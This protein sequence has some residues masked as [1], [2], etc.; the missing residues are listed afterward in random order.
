[1][2]VHLHKRKSYRHRVANNQKEPKV[3]KFLTNRHNEHHYAEQ[4]PHCIKQINIQ[5]RWILNVWFGII[6]DHIIGPEFIQERV[7]A[8]YY[9]NFLLNRLNELLEN[10]PLAHRARMIF[11]QDG[12]P[13]HT[14]HV[15]RHIL[16]QKFPN[17]WIGLHGPQVWPPRS[18]NL[19][20]LDFFAW[21]FLKNKIYENNPEN[22]EDLKTKIRNACN[23]ISSRMLRRV[24][25]NFIRRVALCL[26][27]NSGHFEHLL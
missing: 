7:N 3:Y 4:N 1:M 15:V 23:K 17:K 13:A 12:H 10:V 11:Q 5:G 22:I 20:P 6:G 14:S 18:P 21:G 19:T 9:S 26:E 24:R 2:L 25:E 8:E 27:E 16:N